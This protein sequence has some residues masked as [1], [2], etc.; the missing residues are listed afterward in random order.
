METQ[1]FKRVK[2][3]EDYYMASI[4]GEVYS[5]RFNKFLKPGKSNNGYLKVNISVG[6]KNRF[7]AI[8]RI[9]AETF[10]PTPEGKAEVNHKNG[11]RTDNR[12]ENLEWCTHS[13][14]IQHS[15]KVT[16][17]FKIGERHASAKLNDE[18]IREIRMLTKFGVK[19]TRLANYYRVAQRTIFQIVHNQNWKHVL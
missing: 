14:N 17:T 19:Q 6:G 8:H 10:L 16:K 7:R 15:I 1:F 9:I 12:L 2:G 4:W 13:E 11:I 5:I 3:A 18:K